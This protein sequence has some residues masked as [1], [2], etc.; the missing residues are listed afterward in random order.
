MKFID[1]DDVKNGILDQCDVLINAGY[2]GSAW[3]G[4][5]IWKEDSIVERLTKWVYEGGVFL[6]VNE[7]SAVDGFDNFF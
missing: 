6:G 1:F 4:G 7:P 2:A 5:D 3:S